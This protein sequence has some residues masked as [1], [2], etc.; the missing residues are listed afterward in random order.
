L[1]SF[2]NNGLFSIR[3]DLRSLHVL[4]AHK[5]NRYHI[6]TMDDHGHDR[7]FDATRNFILQT[8]K[9]TKIP[10]VRCI[11]CEMPANIYEKYPLID[12]TFFLS[13]RQHSDFSIEVIRGKQYMNAVCVRCLEELTFHLES[14][15][16][17]KRWDGAKLGLVLGTCYTYDIFAA[18]PCCQDRLRCL[19]C[20]NFVKTGKELPFF[21]DYSQSCQCPHCGLVEHHFVRPVPCVFNRV[22]TNEVR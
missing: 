12:G 11:I 15:C 16:C 14:K 3:E 21:S 5:F 17:G 2:S 6:K 19:R 18:T 1:D 9:K 22:L 4:P 10:C 8:L 13:P 7:S 20:N